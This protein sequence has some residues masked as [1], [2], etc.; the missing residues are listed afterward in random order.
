[1]LQLRVLFVLGSICWVAV[2]G[3][4]Q[5]PA[6]ETS[7]KTKTEKVLKKAFDIE[8]GQDLP[9]KPQPY[10]PLTVKGK[11][12][13]F[14][15]DATNPFTF[16]EAGIT[17][18][19]W[20]VFNEQPY[21]DDGMRGFGEDYGAALAQRE[22][23][24]FLA[25]FA[26]PTVLHQDPRYFAAPKQYSAFRR[27]VYAASRVL[28]TKAD[29]GRQTFNGSYI[30]GGVASASIGSAFIRN[31]DAWTI[32]QDFSINMGVDAGTN[33]LKEFWPSLSAK[34]RI[35]KKLKVVGD[36]FLGG[37]GMPNPKDCET[38]SPKR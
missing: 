31:H 24:S 30:L 32:A 6:P 11:F 8:T 20:Q 33:V 38:E 1:M 14:K 3:F 34:A 25:R 13:Y 37:Q 9:D 5:A 26:I 12:D 21:G 15:K 17:A 18:G 10:Q 35:P 19:S 2:P 16:I 4:T 23:T 27:G 7:L 28:L 29:S 36:F 22:M